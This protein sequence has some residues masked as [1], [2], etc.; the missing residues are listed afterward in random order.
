MSVGVWPKRFRQLYDTRLDFL[1]VREIVVVTGLIYLFGHSIL[2][3]VYS[4][5]CNTEVLLR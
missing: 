2:S 3:N 4:S 1:R 5:L